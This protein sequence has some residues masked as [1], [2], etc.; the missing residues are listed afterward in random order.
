MT[1][2]VPE[3]SDEQLLLKGIAERHTPPLTLGQASDRLERGGDVYR[4]L[5]Q[6]G[7]EAFREALVNHGD[8]I[9]DRDGAASWREMMDALERH[10]V[11]QVAIR[12]T[13]DYWSDNYNRASK[14]AWEV[15]DGGTN[16]IAAA[17]Y[18]KMAVFEYAWPG[19]QD[20]ILRMIPP[21]AGT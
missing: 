20:E 18:V 13:I 16:L 11:S 12:L 4:K 15:P 7:H 6:R 2:D 1:N 17:H 3:L 5:L 8:T 21:A 9:W 14:E 10:E 19:N